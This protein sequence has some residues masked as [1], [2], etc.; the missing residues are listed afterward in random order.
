M[1]NNLIH[2]NTQVYLKP[3]FDYNPRADGL[4]PCKDAGL[5]F[6]KGDVLQV[7]NKEDPNWWQ[8]S[9]CSRGPELKMRREYG[10]KESE[11]SACRHGRLLVEPRA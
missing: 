3:H 10:G 4:I 6:S 5:N 7:V 11:L 2:A 9:N 1:V 8:V